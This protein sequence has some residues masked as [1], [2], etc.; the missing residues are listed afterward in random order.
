MRGIGEFYAPH[1]RFGSA[2]TVW[3]AISKASIYSTA[4]VIA[5]ARS[6]NVDE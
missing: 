4:R 3:P 5:S 2:L 6:S 1:L